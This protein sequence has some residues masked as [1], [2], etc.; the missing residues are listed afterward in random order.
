VKRTFA[1]S[2]LLVLAYIASS[3]GQDLKKTQELPNVLPADTKVEQ[4]ALTND[5]QRTYYTTAA[6][7]IWLYDRGSKTGSRIVMGT[8]W[9]VGVSPL[10]DALVYTQSGPTRQ[11]QHV[12]LLPLTRRQGWHPEMHGV[13]ANILVMSHRFHRRE[14]GRL[15]A[16]RRDRRRAERGRRSD[17][18]SERVVAGAMPSS[19]GTFDGRRTE[20][21]LFRCEPPVPFT[22]AESCL[23]SRGNPRAGNDPA[24]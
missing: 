3:Q 22:C 9:D 15:C 17:R 5:G 1:A 14:M 18:R 21:P 11:E 12:W 13:S 24:L 16:R 19:I 6:G 23:R 8:V 2:A 10:R 7:D 4:F 20:R